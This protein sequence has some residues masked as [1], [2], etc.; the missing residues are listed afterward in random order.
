MRRCLDPAGSQ[1]AGPLFGGQ[2][3]SGL[4]APILKWDAARAGGG[5]ARTELCRTSGPQLPPDDDAP[6][7]RLGPMFIGHQPFPV[8]LWSE[9]Q[10]H[11]A[12]VEL[13]ARDEER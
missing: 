2:P 6:R 4:V 5:A 1:V 10:I 8:D 7:S 3:F 12:T 9:G 13:S 11:M